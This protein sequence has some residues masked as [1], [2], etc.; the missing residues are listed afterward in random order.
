MEKTAL[1]SLL[2]FIQL[3][4]IIA[5]VL[6]GYFIFAH[7]LTTVL[8]LGIAYGLGYLGRFWVLLALVRRPAPSEVT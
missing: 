3:C 8:L 4:L 5:A 2:E 1:Y 7:A 6:A